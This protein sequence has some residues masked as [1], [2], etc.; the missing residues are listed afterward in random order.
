[1]PPQVNPR[2]GGNP[3]LRTIAAVMAGASAMYI[4]Q[5]VKPETAARPAAPAASVPA[6]PA[7]PPP[8]KLSAPKPPP[9]LSEKPLPKSSMLVVPEAGGAPEGVL[10]HYDDDPEGR[11]RFEEMQE[12]DRTRN[13]RIKQDTVLKLK[14]R[15]MSSEFSKAGADGVGRGFTPIESR[16]LGFK[17]AEM[18]KQS[19]P[20][21]KVPDARKS[22]KFIE[23]E[24]LDQAAVTPVA[25]L[26][27][28]GWQPK[29]DNALFIRLGIAAM[30]FL[31]G[32]GFVIMTAGGSAENK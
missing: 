4:I 28:E 19:V 14:R 11:T 22:L 30:V 5:Q 25:V 18:P 23:K 3:L 2:R 24:S 1:M 31:L 12:Y 10:R 17:R 8:L 29:H 32:T 13:S 15:T 16:G 9:D 20:K 21:A 6:K 27:P 26:D 7:P